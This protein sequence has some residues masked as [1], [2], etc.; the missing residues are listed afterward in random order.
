[1]DEYRSHPRRLSVMLRSQSRQTSHAALEGSVE[2]EEMQLIQELAAQ[3]AEV[4]WN[5]QMGRF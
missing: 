2:P 4:A 3:R 5:L 1:M